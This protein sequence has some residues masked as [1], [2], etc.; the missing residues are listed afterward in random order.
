MRTPAGTQFVGN[1]RTCWWQKSF[2][3]YGGKK[4]FCNP[5]HALAVGDAVL[6]SDLS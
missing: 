4:G 5:E 6:L 3:R 1:H 2:E